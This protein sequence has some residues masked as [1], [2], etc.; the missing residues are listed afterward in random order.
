MVNTLSRRFMLAG[1]AF[2][3][4]ASGLRAEEKFID[5]NWKDLLPGDDDVATAFQGIINHDDVP[6]SSEQPASSGVRSDWNGMV[7]RL[8]GYIVPIDQ[9]ADGVTAFLLVPFVGACVH[10]PPPPA[11]QLV[12]VT[13]SIPYPSKGLFE[14]VNVTGMF[15]VSSMRAQGAEIGYALSADRVEPFVY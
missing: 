8:P 15:G 9:S 3:G 6:L 5:L 1:L 4:L 14:A 2:S 11:N 10:V 13:S 12:F 7:V